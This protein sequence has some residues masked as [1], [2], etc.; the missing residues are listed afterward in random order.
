MKK[1]FALLLSVVCLG[2]AL[3]AAGCAPAEQPKFSVN[4]EGELICVFADGTTQ[5]LGKVR[6]EDGKDGADGENGKDGLNGKDGQ[7]GED[8][9]KIT[10]GENGH[11]YID[12]EDT[13]YIAGERDVIEVDMSGEAYVENQP[14]PIQF[15]NVPQ[16][17]H[18]LDE[19]KV[20]VGYKEDGEIRY[21]ALDTQKMDDIFVYYDRLCRDFPSDRNGLL[22]LPDPNNSNIEVSYYLYQSFNE[23]GTPKIMMEHTLEGYVRVN[24]KEYFFKIIINLVAIDEE[25]V[26][27]DKLIDVEYADAF[28]RYICKDGDKL[29]TQ[30]C[31]YTT[32]D[33]WRNPHNDITSVGGG[34]YYPKTEGN[35]YAEDMT[36]MIG[37]FYHEKEYYF[38][39]VAFSFYDGQVMTDE[40][41]FRSVKSIMETLQNSFVVY[42]YEHYKHQFDNEAEV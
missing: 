3:F 37:S 8:G 13:F 42:D 32:A 14:L 17:Q 21:I 34:I 1:L 18:E 40:E 38:L 12:G 7:D 20:K 31:Q 39:S 11:W 19:D 5:N 28:V 4:A 25:Q 29:I 35:P 30:P 6:G 2:M 36:H 33:I 22:F 41:V 9:S 23:D 10:I 27:S 26:S 24:G 16:T 15:R